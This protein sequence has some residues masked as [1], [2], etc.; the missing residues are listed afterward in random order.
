MLDDKSD[1]RE[2]T[3]GDKESLW[4]RLTNW[5]FFLQ[6]A[7]EFNV[8]SKIG[9]AI[10][11]SHTAINSTTGETKSLY[12]ALI[13]NRETG[14]LEMEEGYD[15]VQ[16]YNRD[17]IMEW[18]DDARY[19]IRNNIREVNKQ[20]HGNYA[21]EDRM[22]IQSHALG[23]LA[24]QFHK[25]VVP[26]IQT[27]FRKE[28]FDE[29]LGYTEGRY[30]SFWNFMSYFFKNI[31]ELGS[32]H[33]NYKKHHGVKGKQKLQNAYRTIGELGLFMT[34]I[35]VRNLLVKLFEDDDKVIVSLVN[36]VARV[37]LVVATDVAINFVLTC[38]IL[39][40]A[41]L[42]APVPP[43]PVASVPVTLLAKLID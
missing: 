21:Y 26:S 19:E 35:I 15:Q 10:V 33:E 1:L 36:I 18:N 38:K 27:R 13:F 30:L 4:R 28:Y 11:R 37:P 24:A 9:N 20:I 34:T 23:Q 16:M 3:K 8:Q 6:D 2:Q 32:I 29:N 43:L 7:G 12:D 41:K 40:G 5:G 22:V 17:K 14:A 31:N 39:P 25:W 42:V